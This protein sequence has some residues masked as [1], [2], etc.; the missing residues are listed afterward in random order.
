MTPSTHHA[1]SG[2]T[3]RLL[4]AALLGALLSS[5][6]AAAQPIVNGIT[7][8]TDQ[9]KIPTQSK[10]R[11]DTVVAAINEPQGVFNPYFFHNGWDE[12]V[13]DVIFVRLV[14]LDKQGRPVPELAESWQVSKDG[15]A[16]TLKLRKG[17]TYS[18]GSPLTAQDVAFTLT[19]LHDPSYDG[20]TDIGLA[21]IKGGA[22]YKAGK[23]ASIAGLKV[24]DAQTI[25]IT[26]TEPGA[27][28]LRLIG[29]PVLSKAYY[30]QGYQRGK[31]DGVRALGGK[32]LG[33]GPFVYDKYV[34]GQEVRF[35]ANARYF[36][37]KPAVGNFIYR[38]TSDATKLQ[39]LQTG[40]TDYD[41]FAVNPDNIEQLKSLGFAN[42]NLYNS[43]DY[44]L[45]EFNHRKP[46]LKDLKVR[47]AL[48]YG[49]DRQKLVDV[50]YQGYGSVAT[51]PVTPISW[52]Y[53]TSGINPYKFDPAKARALLDADG[54]KPGSDGIRVKNG[55]RLSLTLLATKSLFNDAL[56]PIAKESYKAIGVELKPEVSDFNSLI[57]KQ[58]A[59]NYD[60]AT[61][62]T[63]N[64]DDPHQGV[65]E[66]TSTQSRI[67]SAYNNPQLDKLV[68]A[69][70]ST[71]DL[72][73]RKQRYQQLYQQFAN[74]PPV[75][76]L[77]YRKIL[78]ASNA[79]VS[80]FSP[81]V[82]NGIIASLPQLKIAQ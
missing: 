34:P 67:K 47:Q 57:G 37:G 81:N 54:W 1:F 26:T 51:V 6:L 13:T 25:Q 2:L 53:T 66:F 5:Q 55:Q 15:L 30:G 45:I 40:E 17:L 49:L 82:Y 69:A 65:E 58:K 32:P 64:L 33:A 78:S 63:S 39:L 71:L 74:D 80:G 8:A 22:D 48:I 50:V 12:N 73:V 18:D 16:Y 43:S 61:Y 23:A 7:A 36:R 24:I 4:P 14:N 44:S 3:R 21:H 68:A 27:T 38:I 76:L 77:A 79:R 41:G 75:I 62:R 29:G 10:A 11:K 9:A 20:E 19:V 31:L 56:I 42:I 60:L 59:G 52:A 28:T 46:Y 70:N 72:N 35:H